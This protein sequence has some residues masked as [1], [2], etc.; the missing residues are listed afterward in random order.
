MMKKIIFSILTV[1]TLTSTAFALEQSDTDEIHHIIDHFKHIW[2]VCNGHGSGDF[3]AENGDFVNIFGMHFSGKDEIESRHVAIH[4]TFL[5]NSI[6]EIIDLKIR[7]AKSDV[8]VVH[9]NWKVSN[10]HIPGTGLTEMKGIFTHMLIKSD[11]KWEITASQNT[12]L[13]KS[14]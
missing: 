2:N 7:E 8:V 12:P 3:Y 14:E 9:V 6:F 1:L 4:E 13:Y 5:M 11:G 10:V